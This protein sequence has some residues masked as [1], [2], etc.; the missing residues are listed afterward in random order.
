MAVAELA[1]SHA[2][3]VGDVLAI[4]DDVALELG[5]MRIRERGGHGGHNGL[6]SVIENLGSED[7]P[8]LRIGIRRGEMQGDLAEYVLA[9]FPEEDVLVVQEVVG[10]AVEAVEWSMREGTA[11]AM[12]RYN[13]PLK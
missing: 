5:T 9:P 6:R 3:S 13:G 11:A 12:S 1:E 4:I 8:R 10:S 2:V 7:F